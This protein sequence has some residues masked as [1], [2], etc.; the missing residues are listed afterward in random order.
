MT[1]AWST[2]NAHAAQLQGWNLFEIWDNRLELMIQKV[3]DLPIFKTDDD[4][5][6]FVAAKAQ[7]GDKLAKRAVELS[8]ISRMGNVSKKT[9]S[10][11]NK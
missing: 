9:S 5:R 8:V 2:E 1:E 11:R 6:R 10:R 3:D 7:A 4:A